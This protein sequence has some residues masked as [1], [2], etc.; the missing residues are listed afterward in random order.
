MLFALHFAP[1]GINMLGAASDFGTH[2]HAVS[3]A[4]QLADH[5]LD[6]FVTIQPLFIQQHAGNLLVGF[7]LQVAKGQILQFPFD[8]ADPQA[9]RQRAHRYRKFHGPHAVSTLGGGVLHLAN[10]KGS[11]RQLDQGH[12]HIVN[13]GDQHLAHVVEL[14]LVLREAAV[15]GVRD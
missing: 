7:R 3:A 5:V 12:P 6:I 2:A 13:H 15:C 9:V 4:F 1:D 10:G 11:F 14:L 8:L